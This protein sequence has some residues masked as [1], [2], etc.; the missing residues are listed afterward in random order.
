MVALDLV[1]GGRARHR[2]IDIEKAVVGVIR[3]EAQPE[4]AALAGT[5]DR[6]I[7][8]RRRENLS[9]SEVEDLDRPGLLDNEQPAGSLG[10]E[11]AKSVWLSPDA[12]RVAVI[13]LTVPC[14]PF[15][16]KP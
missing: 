2:A 12:T 7:E 6:D 4:Q 1:V 3:I 9:G 8:K 14:G 16:S 10:T 11:V 15:G 5:V 13:E